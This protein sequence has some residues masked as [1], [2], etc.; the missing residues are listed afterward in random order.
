MSVS[1]K[2]WLLI[3]IILALNF[4]SLVSLYSSLHRSGEFVGK[5][6][7]LKQVIW[8]IL[9]WSIAIIF[10]FI[11][12]R[13]FYDL[14][15]WVYFISLAFLLIVASLGKVQMGAQRWLEFLG[16]TFQ[17]S[18]IAKLSALLIICRFF[19]GEKKVSFSFW[20]SFFREVIKPF[21]PIMILFLAI[22]IQPDLGTSLILIFLFLLMLIGA[23][24][25]R[26]N[27]I[28][29]MLILL[30]SLP[31]GW[32]LLKDYQRARLLVFVNPN[33]DPLGA[34]YTIIQSKIAV[35]SGRLLGKGFLSGTQNQLN[36][37]PARHTDFIFTVF[38]EEWG[39][40]GCIF[41]LFLYY[42]LLKIIL[43]IAS[44]LKDRFSYLLCIGI[45]SLFFIHIFINISMVMGLLPVVGL[46]LLF[47]SYG[48][49]YTIINFILI[50]IFLNIIKTHKEI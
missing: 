41:L 16:I 4:I 19:S 47:F 10:S 6:I 24:L 21:I 22:F 13:L 12:Y 7:F 29:F 46:P 17:P 36:F 48:G 40:L 33:S 49:T 9:G 3:L 44:K 31:L 18:E 8:I 50:G 1:Q 35:G 15:V 5:F 23:G 34:G 20:G 45:F 2:K 43:D 39:F 37:I 27:L 42:W 11:N 25:R 38:A 30:L 28:L 32:G 26:R 14:S